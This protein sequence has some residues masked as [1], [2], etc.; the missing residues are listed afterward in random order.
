MSY[1]YVGKSYVRRDGVAKVR[2]EAKYV[3]D[4][5]T[6]G[7][8]HAKVLHSPVAHARIKSINVDKARALP[9]VAV[10]L[11]HEDVPAHPYSGTGHPAPEDTPRDQRIIDR[12]VRF[13][14]DTV[15][16]VA[17]ETPEIA[18]KALSLIDVEYEELPFY[19]DPHEAIA[20]GAVEIHEGT[21]NLLG[22]TVFDVGDVK[23]GFAQADY[24]FEDSF[25]TPI[26][27]HTPMETHVSIVIPET[28]GSI[29]VHTSNQC[30]HVCRRIL[31]VA[32]DMP[33]SKI[34]VI[35]AEIGGGF[36]GKQDTVQEPL[37]AALALAAGRPVFFEFTRE[38]EMYYGRTR[39]SVHFNVKTG[40]MK[41]GTIVARQMDALSNTGAYSSHGHIV[42]MNAMGQFSALYPVANMHYRARTAYTNS[43]VAGAM[44]AYGIPQLY[45]ATEAHMDN[46]AAQIGMDPIELREKNLIKTGDFDAHN[47][48]RVET[49]GV[50]CILETGRVLTD[51]NNRRTVQVDG[52]KR[53]ALG[54]ACFSY[55]Q[56]TYPHGNE[57]AGARMTIVEDGSAVLAIGSSE[58][59]QGNDTAML[60]IAAEASGI[61]VDRI[62]LV[63]G[64]TDVCPMDW[65]AYASRQVS[66]S[67][68]AVK[69]AAEA[70]KK[71]MIEVASGKMKELSENL[72]VRSCKIVDTR[73]NAERADLG[74]VIFDHCY[75]LEKPR[76]ISHEVY[77]SPHTNGITVG[78]VFA[79]V[80]VDMGTGRVDVKKIWSL[81]DA[82]TIINPQMAEGQ[83]H[84]GVFMSYGY[85]LMEQLLLDPKTGKIL[86]DNLLDYKMPTILDMPEMEVHFEQT[87]DP[88]SAYGNKS[89]GEPPTIAPA[90]A[91]RNAVRQ[92]TGI[93]FTEIPLTP[94][95]V[96]LAIAGKERGENV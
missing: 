9:G 70:C 96:R 35:R 93:N 43:P 32:L 6:E 31:G 80:E 63:T 94:Q 60:Q 4:L 14:G 18:Q 10:V 52:N 68:M 8:L 24:V 64:D 75:N 25:K 3:A 1:E 49:C 86:N 36:G 38:E 22:D 87:H 40:V 41:D 77:Y 79:D 16:A 30:P 45:F 58:I 42:L 59:G 48:Y 54:V 89:L 50:Q 67:G 88:H 57:M 46:I 28:D 2:G 15:A 7:T 29:T 39:H 72:D 56:H 5:L 78:A 27:V 66:V 84:G 51:W 37:N 13:A 90:V 11:T 21:G 65:G 69:M 44:R 82:G 26:V 47:N 76:V 55:A 17:A 12:V 20:P 73:S 81:I 53:R 71:E 91:I 61:P 19:L 83:V 74:D 95:R 92:A 62:K 34:H 33:V 85:G 23:D